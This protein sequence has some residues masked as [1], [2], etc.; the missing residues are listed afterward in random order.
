MIKRELA[1]IIQKQ[2]Q[3]GKSLFVLGPRQV[4]KTTLAKRLR[5][6][7]ELNLA[8]TSERLKYERAP[9]ILSQKALA[10]KKKP[11]IYSDCQSGGYP[12]RQQENR[13]RQTVR[14]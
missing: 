12:G 7:L 10:F 3:K 2:L 5:V 8:T 13:H 9:E 4:G 14:L 6:D 11:L 1:A